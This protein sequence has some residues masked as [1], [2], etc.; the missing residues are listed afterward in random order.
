MTSVRIVARC[1]II[2][3]VNPACSPCEHA[4][5]SACYVLS[6]NRPE[7][8]DGVLIGGPSIAVDPFGQVMVETTDPIAV[9]TLTSSVVR[10]LGE[11]V[12]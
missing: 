5:T 11:A 12:A 4:R 10:S 8:E 2:L 6:V 1:D 3:H 7:A 9:A